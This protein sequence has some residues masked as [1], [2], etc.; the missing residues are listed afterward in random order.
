MLSPELADDDASLN[1]LAQSHL[2]GEDDTLGERR[3]EG[4]KGRHHLM[5]IQIH[6]CLGEHTR[7]FVIIRTT[8][9]A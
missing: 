1:G 2:V 6:A 7:Q 8:P 5:W 9:F 4:E 3:L